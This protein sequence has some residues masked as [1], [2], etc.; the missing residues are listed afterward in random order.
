MSKERINIKIKSLGLLDLL[1]FKN[2]VPNRKKK[3]QNASPTAINEVPPM[4][5]LAL[6][7]HPRIQHLVIDSIKEETL[8]TKTYRFRPDE[9][10]GTSE[11]AYF[12]SGQYLSFNFNIEGSTVTRPYSISSSPDKTLEGCYEITVKRDEGGFVSNYIWDNW[13]IGTKVSCSG[14]EGY[15]YYDNLRDKRNLVALAGGCGITP[16]RSMAQSIIDGTLDI[17]L[18]IFYGSNSKEDIIFYD[19]LNAIENESNGKIHVIHV[20]AQEELEGFE[21]GFITKELLEKRVNIN[22]SSFFICGPQA[23]YNFVSGEL[24]KLKLRRKFVRREV[25]G[26]IKDV[27]S[28]IDFPKDVADKEFKVKV[29]IGGISKEIK[30]SAKESLLVAIE[31]AGLC[32]P[33]SCRSGLCAICRSLLISGNV[34]IPEDD[35]GRRQADIQFGYIHPCASFPT[36]DLEIIIPREKK[37]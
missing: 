30:A 23:M 21:K 7:L 34:Y 35:D 26:E 25:F 13:S 29:H 10:K 22:D 28:L 8:S 16:F 17:N 19:E 15:F 37:S 6:K 36:S 5:A 9:A 3:I 2:L 24:G 11:L 1:A 20:L 31:R 32:P 4:N 12:R 18:T 27:E 14:P 33:S